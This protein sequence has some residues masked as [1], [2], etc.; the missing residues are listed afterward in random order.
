MRNIETAD[1][2]KVIPLASEGSTV[3]TDPDTE[4]VRLG[5]P[6]LLAMSSGKLLAS[7][8]QYGSGVKHLPGIKG[9][10][11]R[12]KHWLQGRLL[13]S[14]NNGETWS[15]QALYP[16]CQASLFR[17][18]SRLFLL[19]HKG[20]LQIMESSDGGQTWSRPADLT[21][22]DG[23]GASFWAGP[24]T[25]LNTGK[26][27]YAVVLAVTDRRHKGDPG[28]VLAPILMRAS[29]GRNLLDKKSWMFSSPA[30]PF[31]EWIP[32]SAIDYL[33]SPICKLS[34][35][36]SGERLAPG[37]WVNHPGWHGAV[38]VRIEDSSHRWFDAD[39]KSVHLLAWAAIHQPNYSIL[40]KGSENAGRLQL[41]FEKTQ[42][43]APQTI[44]PIPGGH[45]P[46]DIIYDKPS[47]LYWMISNQSVDSMARMEDLPH[48]RKGLPCDEL[49]R[50]Q[51][52]FSKNLVDWCFAGLIDAAG[53]PCVSCHSPSM[54]V[55]KNDLC[56][57]C[58]T[59]NEEGKSNMD[60]RRITF[61]LIPD[62]RELAY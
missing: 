16:F 35:S 14:D 19:G 30:T 38:P 15:E 58:A 46:F 51:L 4:G 11:A 52:H 45:L 6:S 36:N 28:A 20:N 54:A 47:K 53:D 57:L 1:Q 22:H 24:S 27:I 2:W 32:F 17:D 55:K 10:H 7:L 34:R 62:F 33:G 49:H 12:D 61:R 56:C 59:G 41:E 13:L 48:E 18:G 44:V 29:A 43:D 9:R 3:F 50:L 37:R 23:E 60:T 21:G 40:L 26:Y 8:D 5:H 39:E 25:V 42:S 31:R